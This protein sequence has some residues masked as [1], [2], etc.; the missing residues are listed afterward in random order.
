MVKSSLH[1]RVSIQLARST[2]YL[3]TAIYNRNESKHIHNPISRLTAPPSSRDVAG[4]SDDEREKSLSNPYDSHSVFHQEIG[5]EA[6][7]RPD[8]WRYS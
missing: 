8:K 7:R 5:D 6:V 4:V 3:S 2:Y 1:P